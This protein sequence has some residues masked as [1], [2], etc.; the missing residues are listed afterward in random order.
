[1]TGVDEPEPELTDDD[2][3]RADRLQRDR[4]MV[5]HG[6]RIGGLPGAM[7]AGAMIALRDVI[8]PP[9]DDRPVAE[10]EAPSDPH[11]VDR[12]GVNLGPDEIGGAANVAVEPQ[13]RRPPVV[14][15]RRRRARPR[16][17]PRGSG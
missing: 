7:M 15:G 5:E 14:A 12:D 13:P 11:D 2:V 3:R 1:V 4:S 9:R 16:S 6:R 8:E 17:G 10:V